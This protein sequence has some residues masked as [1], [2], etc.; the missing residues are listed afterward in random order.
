[1]ETM[2]TIAARQSCRAYTGE[3]IS[4][5]ELQTILEAANAAPVGL[6]NYGEV[7][8]TVIQDQEIIAKIDDIAS[9]FFGNPEMNPTYG[10]STLILVSAKM[11]D[12]ALNS[13]AYCN[14][15]CII[16]NMMLATTDLGLGSVYLFAVAQ[17]LS[18]Q[19]DFCKELKVPDGFMPVSATVVG[20]SSVPALERAL[21][22]SRIATEFLR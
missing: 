17:A 16:E 20:K 8:L 21:T 2:K 5:G 12:D 3:Q 13:V 6:G 9:K 15:A 7:E 11:T 19:K 4:E 10:A 1:M 22:T 18:T 14:A